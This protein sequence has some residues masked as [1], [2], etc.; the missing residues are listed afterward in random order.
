MLEKSAGAIIYTTIKEKRYYLLS[1]D[2]HNNYGFAK[3]HLEE[4]ETLQDAAI[5]EIQ[6]EVGLDV[7]LDDNFKEELRYIMPNGI[8]KSSTYFIAYYSNQEIKPQLEEVQ[9]TIL[10]PYE[11]ALNKLTFDSMKQVLKKADGYLNEKQRTT[12]TN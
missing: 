12:T 3:G 2:F 10:L 8:E 11:E 5:R 6:E 4:N 9:E 1:K 7:I